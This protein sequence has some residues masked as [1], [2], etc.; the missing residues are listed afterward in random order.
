MSK[1]LVI[2]EKPSVARDLAVV[3]GD[4]EEKEGFFEGDDFVVTFAVG[5]LFEL[6]APHEV[7]SLWT[8]KT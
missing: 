8:G 5:H 3:L 2:T 7:K 1:A 6:L 4:L